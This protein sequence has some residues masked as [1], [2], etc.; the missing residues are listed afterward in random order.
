MVFIWQ[1]AYDYNEPITI[2][3]GKCE[4]GGTYKSHSTSHS[5]AGRSQGSNGR[6]F[7]S[8]VG[9]VGHVWRS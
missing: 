5:T 9:T 1:L 4:H 2:E 6:V 3:L 8:G 7:D